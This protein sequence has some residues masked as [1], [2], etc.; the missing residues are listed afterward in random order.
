[1]VQLDVEV[2]KFHELVHVGIT[3]EGIIVADF[4][5]ICRSLVKHFQPASFP[6]GHVALHVEHFVAHAYIVHPIWTRL[7]SLQLDVHARKS[8]VHLGFAQRGDTQS[9]RLEQAVEALLIPAHVLAG[10]DVFIVG[11]LFCNIE[12]GELGVCYEVAL[13]GRFVD[14]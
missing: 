2:C 4:D 7:C 12:F 9:A 8:W 6:G 13:L 3:G 11:L 14:H 10:S 5:V 1:L